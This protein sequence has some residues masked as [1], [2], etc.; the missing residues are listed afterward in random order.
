MIAIVAKHIKSARL[1][2]DSLGGQ[3]NNMLP[4]RLSISSRDKDMSD[5]KAI[6]Q[7]IRVFPVVEFCISPGKAG[8][9]G[10][11]Q[12]LRKIISSP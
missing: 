3:L 2:M 5:D 10:D 4:S 12:L 6:K 9:N 7:T 8:Q 1:D 11:C